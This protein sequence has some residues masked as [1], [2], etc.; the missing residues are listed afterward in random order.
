MLQNIAISESDIVELQPVFV[1]GNFSAT[2]GTR[3]GPNV[4][5]LGKRITTPGLHESFRPAPDRGAQKAFDV[6]PPE[7][8]AGMSAVCNQETFHAGLGVC[9]VFLQSCGLGPYPFRPEVIT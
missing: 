2:D 8:Q 9:H 4:A 6:L 7:D 3:I 1:Q 5:H